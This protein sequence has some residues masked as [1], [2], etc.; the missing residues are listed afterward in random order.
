MQ[1]SKDLKRFHNVKTMLSSKKHSMPKLQSSSN[2]LDMYLL[3]KE[4]ER[5]LQE[6]ERVGKRQ[7]QIKKRLD[8]IDQELAKSS[9]EKV[10]VK[11][12]KKTNHTGKKVQREKWKTMNLNY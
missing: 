4:R 7:D 9:K 12:N 1:N 5:I 2:Y 10:T 8:E 3:E 11:K 6:I